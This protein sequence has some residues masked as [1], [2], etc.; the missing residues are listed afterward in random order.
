MW[1]ENKKVDMMDEEVKAYE[2]DF[3]VRKII[4]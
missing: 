1:K 3:F 2:V 4:D